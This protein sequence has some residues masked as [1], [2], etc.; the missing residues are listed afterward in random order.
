MTCVKLRELIRETPSLFLDEI[1][2]WLALYHDVPISTTALHNNLR[3]LGLTY[4][5]L[6]K[7]AAERNDIARAD[8]LLEITTLYTADQLVI[9]DE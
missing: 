1:G 7:A 4:K 8:W 3:Q 6:R 5:L 9:L 2:E